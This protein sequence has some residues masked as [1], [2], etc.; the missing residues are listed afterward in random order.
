MHVKNRAD[1][2]GKKNEILLTENKISN[3]SFERRQ[4][5]V[6]TWSVKVNR[7]IEIKKNKLITVR[8]VGK[9]R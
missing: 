9:Y 8:R 4:F 5:E 3:N 1:K 2:R 7:Q 6:E